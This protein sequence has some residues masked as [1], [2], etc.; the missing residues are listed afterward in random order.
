M[1]PPDVRRDH[2]AARIVAIVIAVA[3]LDAS[4][5]ASPVA[6]PAIEGDEGASS[7]G[8]WPGVWP[9]CIKL[10]TPLRAA[11]LAQ[12]GGGACR[13]RMPEAKPGST[14][15]WVTWRARRDVAP[16][17]SAYFVTKQALS[18]PTPLIF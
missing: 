2:K 10:D 9:V 8:A 18:P 12:E 11:T 5:Q 14:A 16:R 15:A 4:S 3:R 1:P 13:V 7:L 6:V 17:R